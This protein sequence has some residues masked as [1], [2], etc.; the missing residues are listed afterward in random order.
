[1]QMLCRQCLTS[2]HRLTAQH[3]RS[4]GQCAAGKHNWAASKLL[5]HFDLRNQLTLVYR[6]PSKAY[7]YFLMCREQRFCTG[8]GTCDKAHSTLERDVWYLERDSPQLTNE[9]LVE[10][11][12]IPR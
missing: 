2:D 11:V 8:R 1:M 4:P 5:S 6:R 12:R 3:P 10:Q 7:Q 9:Q